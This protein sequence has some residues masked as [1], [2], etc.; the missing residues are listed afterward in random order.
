LASVGRFLI[1]EDHPFQRAL[2][3]QMLRGLGQEFVAAAADGAEAM[4]ILRSTSVD[5]V[6]SDLMMPGVDGIE[7]LPML[8]ESAPGVS[9]ILCSA[10]ET[11]LSVASAIARAH[12]IKL[13]AA[14]SKPVTPAKLRQVL[15]GAFPA[16]AAPASDGS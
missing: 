2:L 15:V 4:R 1:V 3:E 8:R 6:I 12:G 10:D 9:L 5:V 13:L 16:D 7:L 14:I 11:S